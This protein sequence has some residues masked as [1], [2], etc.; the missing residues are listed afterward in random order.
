MVAE[1]KVLSSRRSYEFAPDGLRL[2]VLSGS[3]A[4]ER[5]RLAFDFQVANI[6]T[7]I[8]LFGPVPNTI[9]PG[10]VFN[11]GVARV[12]GMRVPIRLL[13]FEARRIVI[14]IAGPSVLID[15]VYE[16]LRGTVADLHAP[17]GTPALA[18]PDSILNYSEVSFA[19]SIDPSAII[20]PGL[21]DVLSASLNAGRT[22]VR[23]L[24]EL[25]GRVL[26]LDE[27]HAG[28]NVSDFR[29]FELGLRAGTRPDEGR[30]F[31]AAPLDTE[32]HLSLLAR[33]ESTVKSERSAE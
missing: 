16:N 18:E 17:D 29:A 31:S 12:D 6:G 15:S 22:G 24:P 19:A 8:P 2:T 20:S 4:L 1:A 26:G 9:P 30:Y 3:D 33:I 21:L 11:Y 23:F 5:I 7:P 13:H 10:I 25:H 14:D 27:E 28:T 32:S